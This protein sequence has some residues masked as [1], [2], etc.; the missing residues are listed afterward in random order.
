MYKEPRL[1]RLFQ[2]WFCSHFNFHLLH[3]LCTH[4]FFVY[5]IYMYAL[6]LYLI[7]EWP[8]FYVNKDMF[9]S[10]QNFITLTWIAWYG[11]DENISK[12]IKVM[13]WT[14]VSQTDWWT[15]MPGW[16]LSLPHPL[17]VR[18]GHKNYV[19]PLHLRQCNN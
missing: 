19:V 18:L 16:F 1:N 13:E 5:H 2:G 10:V 11:K 8:E 9:C 14:S 12:G 4:V 17:L 6:F 15:D 3:A 7:R